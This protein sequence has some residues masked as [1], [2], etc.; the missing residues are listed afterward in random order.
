MHF[1]GQHH[2]YPQQIIAKTLMV[3]IKMH[4][5]KIIL[6]GD[7]GQKSLNQPRY[8]TKTLYHEL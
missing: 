6:F 5:T 3:C 7:V 4:T 1:F 8:M 2:M